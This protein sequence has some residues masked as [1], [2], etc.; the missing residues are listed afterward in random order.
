MAL[1][2]DAKGLENNVKEIWMLKGDKA[3]ILK[4]FF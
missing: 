3:D 1:S 2:Q 4:I